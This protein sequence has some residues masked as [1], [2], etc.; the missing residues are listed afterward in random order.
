VKCKVGK[1]DVCIGS[2]KWVELLLKDDQESTARQQ[3][4]AT[5]EVVAAHE[6][7]GH[8]TLVLLVDKVPVLVMACADAL[9]PEART[10]VAALQALSIRCCMVTGDNETTAL[11]VA[12]RVGIHP[13][14]VF[15][16]ILPAHKSRKVCRSEKKYLF[17]F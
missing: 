2:S 12:R 4:R 5:F 10:C 11:A 6:K 3:Y 14:D 13:R 1:H 8:T 17:A 16:G 9:K 7:Q 15:A